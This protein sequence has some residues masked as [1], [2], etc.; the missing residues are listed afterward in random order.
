MESGIATI[1]D[2]LE[3]LA[4]V[5]GG[6]GLAIAAITYALSRKSLNHAV[7]ISCIS[8]FQEILDV[9]ERQ[10]LPSV[11]RRYLDLCNEEMFYFQHRYLRR[12]VALEWIDGMMSVLPLL[13]EEGQPI[14]GDADGETWAGLMR[15]FPRLV[16]AFSAE[17]HGH[18]TDP[19]DRRRTARKI[20]SRVRS[21]SH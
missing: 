6:I 1:K 9:L 16:N 3:L 2:L 10:P 5:A 19:E 7:M 15:G 4:I 14:E 12:E 11:R 18:M 21:Y 20:L 13:D 17:R 8:R